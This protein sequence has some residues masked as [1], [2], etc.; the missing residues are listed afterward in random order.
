MDRLL[1][2]K[3]LCFFLV[4]VII[5]QS[6]YTLTA[7]KQAA[8]LGPSRIF[9]YDRPSS[10]WHV[11]QEP[12]PG[13]HNDTVD[14]LTAAQCGSEFPD[15]YHEVDRA[16]A[17]W[18]ARGHTIDEADTST[19]WRHDGAFKILIHD[20]ELRILETKGV[21]GGGG[22]YQMRSLSVL[23]MLQQALWSASVAGESLPTIEATVVVD[24]MSLLPNGHGDTHSIWTFTSHL[25]NRDHDRH[26][27]IP[28]F[29]F[30]S[31]PA[32]GSFREAR[33]RATAHDA[34][35]ADKL[36]Q[37]VW[38]GV[39]WTNEAIRG[40]LL[41]RTRDQPWADARVTD[42]ETRANVLP[43]DDLCRYAFTLHSEGRSYSG[44]LQFLL[45]C[46]SVPVVHDLEWNAHFYH[47]LVRE[48]PRQ[49]YV[50]VGRDFADLERQVAYYLR[51]PREAQ[52]VVDN[53]IATFRD[54]YTT[55]AATS[56]YLRRL[57]RGYSTVSFAPRVDRVSEDGAPVYRRGISFE[58]F[59]HLND[60]YHDGG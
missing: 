7:H 5:H 25:P 8:V 43:A 14:A 20:N 19:A 17:H 36:P 55:A 35:V 3:K 24:D 42:W 57:I 50:P 26:W 51:H 28:D 11:P 44:R 13:L 12:I 39:Q 53:S 16:V 4:A 30:Y 29:A 56:C 54:K 40:A 60:E 22:G 34:P 48:G 37:A 52:R 47:L 45:N 10:H 23:H 27:L 49:N 2:W 1:S 21:F 46:A 9:T 15:L 58:E 41:D 6:F 38:R 18:R 31:A 33:R 32:T 59:V